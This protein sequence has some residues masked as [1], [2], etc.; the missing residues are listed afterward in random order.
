MGYIDT[1]LLDGEQ[2][3]YRTRLH[4]II[5]KWTALWL[6][7]GIW[8]AAAKNGDGATGGF[9][10]FIALILGALT[11]GDYKSSEFGITNKRVLIK[12]GLIRTTSLETLLVKVEG[13]QVDQGLIGR[14]FNYGTII[15]TGTGGTHSPFKRISA[16]MDFRKRVQEQI[17]LAEKA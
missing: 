8:I 5:Y 1:N 6:L 13:I 14:I 12:I 15:I 7:L 11:Y 2:I 4:W 17:S 9:F 3:V 16:P 10:I